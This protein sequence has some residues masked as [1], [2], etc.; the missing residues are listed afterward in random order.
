MSESEEVVPY[1]DT[2]GGLI[3][4]SRAGGKPTLVYREANPS[5]SALMT[6][7]IDELKLAI[8]LL[9]DPEPEIGRSLKL[10]FAAVDM[11]QAAFARPGVEDP[12]RKE[13]M[14]AVKRAI[15]KLQK[16]R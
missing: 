10:L 4:R 7:I 9:G 12:E 2:A 1:R 3:A 8:T 16:I 6:P 5:V 13:G 15:R 14:A 11:V